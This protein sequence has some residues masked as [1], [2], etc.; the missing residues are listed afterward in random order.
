MPWIV[1]LSFFILLFAPLVSPV[2][3]YAEAPLSTSFL[4]RLES[5]VQERTLS[6]GMKVLFYKRDAAPVFAGYTSVRVGGVNELPGKTGAS[7]L[8]EHIAFKGS[9]VIGTKNYQR[10]SELL[11]ELEFLKIKEA[12]GQ[13]LSEEEALRLKEI[14]K[15]LEEEIWNIPEFT[16][17]FKRWGASGMNA[18]TAKELTNYFTS[19]PVSSFEHWAWAESERLLAPVTRQF[20]KEKDVVLEERRMR[21]ENSPSGKLYE[22]LLS[23]SF[24]DHSYKHPVIGYEEDLHALVPDDVRDLHKKYYVASNMVVSVVGDLELS[25]ALPVLE[26]YFGRIPNGDRP[27]QPDTVEPPQLQERMVKVQHD[28]EP[29]F[30]LGYKQPVYPDAD[31]IA[32]NIFLEYLFGHVEAPLYKRL[33]MEKKITSSIGFF[34]AP[35]DMFPNMIIIAGEPIKP[36]GND[37]VIAE[38]DRGIVEYQS[39]LI[40]LEELNIIKKSMLKGALLSL[41]SNMGIAS[42]LA[43]SEQLYGDWKASLDWYQQMIEVTQEDIQRVAKKYFVSTNR[44]KAVLSRR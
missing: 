27:E 17:L 4:K 40:P 23:T 35:G 19:F 16:G 21:Y 34:D 43:K 37:D 36:Y 30:F 31:P 11:P 33:V 9:K 32:I 2:V 5:R 28:A 26:H 25:Q 14:S 41:K 6:N 15:E 24:T 10:E 7:H 38:I 42:N 22:K 12:K 1:F 13:S 18:T 29:V 20:F 8:F 39:K 3:S 44:T